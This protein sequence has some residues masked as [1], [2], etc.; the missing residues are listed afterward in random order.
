MG[1]DMK[2]KQR[3]HLLW[4]H[5]WDELFLG[6]GCRSFFGFKCFA[7]I[8]GT[9]VNH[10]ARKRIAF[11]SNGTTAMGLPWFPRYI[12]MATSVTGYTAVCSHLGSSR[13]DD[14]K[15]TDGIKA[16]HGGHEI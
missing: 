9:L 12:I 8:A 5:R 11:K 16:I 4:P 1:Y 3:G 14:Q 6:F 15:L 10:S 7:F 2:V 13:M